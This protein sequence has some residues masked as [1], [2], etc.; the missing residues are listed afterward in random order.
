MRFHL[1]GLPNAPAHPAF[2]LCGFAQAT[3]RFAQMLKSLGHTVIFYGADLSNPPCD[4]FVRTITNQARQTI[5]NGLN[6]P[7]QSARIDRDS[8]LWKHSN[9]LAI[10]A[11]QKRKQP[12]DFLLTIGGTSQQPVFD[13]HPDLLGVEYSVGYPGSFAA[14]RVFES[15]AWQHHSY[16]AQ[17]ITNGRFFDTV[18]PLFFDPEAFPVRLDPG[19]YLLFVGRL[20]RGKGIGIAYE[21]ARRSGIPLKVV[22]H[23]GDLPLDVGNHE[24]L[25]EVSTSH[26]NELMS[27]AL[28]VVCPTTYIEPFNAVAVEAQLC[29]T[30]VLST[31]WGGFTETVEHGVTGYRCHYLGDFVRAAQCAHV[32]DREQIAQRAREKY[33]MAALAFEYEAYFNRLS[34]L[35]KDGWNSLD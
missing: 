34:L 1:L 9:P 29:G 8:P 30:P 32:L 25:G 20:T 12:G 13:A 16:G 2:C 33:S 31:D 26:R 23:G 18:I 10:Q 19:K 3:H 17:G 27:G 22:G 15:R 11:I 21:V 4:E 14:H 24:Y 6:V 35:W 5:L 28:A 7:Y